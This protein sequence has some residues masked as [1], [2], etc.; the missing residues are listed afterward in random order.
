MT[1]AD[2][3]CFSK[4]RKAFGKPALNIFYRT[5]SHISLVSVHQLPSECRAQSG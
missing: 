2:C 1:N 3:N 5:V 4:A